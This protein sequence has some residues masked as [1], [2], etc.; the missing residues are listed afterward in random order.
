MPIRAQHEPDWA[1]ILDRDQRDLFIDCDRSHDKAPAGLDGLT[2]DSSA[3]E[4]APNTKMC[5]SGKSSG[6]CFKSLP[7]LVV[8]LRLR[9]DGFHINLYGMTTC[10]A[11]AEVE[12][13]PRPLHGWLVAQRCQ[14]LA[15][16]E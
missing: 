15:F 8:I 14:V 10:I 6:K 2:E 13:L 3:A 9:R 1:A 16:V 7:P 11:K 5:V 12:R 4:G